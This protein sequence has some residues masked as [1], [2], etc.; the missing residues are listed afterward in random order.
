VDLCGVEESDWW[1][2]AIVPPEPG[3][4]MFVPRTSDGRV[5]AVG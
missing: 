1:H 4:S 5:P 3:P 2:L